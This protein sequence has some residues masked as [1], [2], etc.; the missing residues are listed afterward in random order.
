MKKTKDEFKKRC[1]EVDK[2]LDAL[3]LLDK[4][5]CQLTCTDKKKTDKGKIDK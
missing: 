3:S 4:G 5:N 2:Y 1:V